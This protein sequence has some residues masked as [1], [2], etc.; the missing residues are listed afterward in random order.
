MANEIVECLIENG[1]VLEDKPKT[2]FS[3]D[4]SVYTKQVSR[5]CIIRAVFIGESEVMFS[6]YLYD[7]DHTYRRITFSAINLRTKADWNFICDKI[8]LFERYFKKV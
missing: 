8:C 2:I 6:E 3:S 1:F 5:T 7:K 4:S